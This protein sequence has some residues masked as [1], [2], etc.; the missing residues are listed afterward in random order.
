MMIMMMMMMKMMKMMKM[1]KMKLQRRRKAPP[2]AQMLIL[3][4]KAR[5][6][7]VAETERQTFQLSKC[8]WGMLAVWKKGQVRP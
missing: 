6:R 7:S 5:R 4:A 3:P 8:D 2:T 1:I